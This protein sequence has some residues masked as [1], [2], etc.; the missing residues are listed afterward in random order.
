MT[1]EPD[2]AA[3]LDQH[4]AGLCAWV[5]QCAGGALT[6]AER[7]AGGSHRM[8]WQVDAAQRE[9]FLTLDA[10]GAGGEDGNARDA[11]VLSALADTPLPVPGLVGRDGPGGALLM[12]RVAGR[13]DAPSGDDLEP[14]MSDLMQHMATLH[15]LDPG[16]LSLPA[17]VQPSTAAGIALDQLEPLRKTYFATPAAHHP[18][19]DF[20]LG[21]LWRHAPRSV[22]RVA[23]VHGD[24][25]PGNMLYAEGRVRAIVDWEIAHLGDPMEDLA[26]L[27]TRDMS[28][29]IGDF[30]RRLAQ[31]QAAGGARLDVDRL[32]YYRA[33]VLIR[34]SL[35]IRLTLANSDPALVP[36]QLGAFALLLRRAASQAL[37][38]A[39]GLPLPPLPAAMP[40]APVDEHADDALWI[41][42]LAARAQ[43]ECEEQRDLMGPLFE[44][45]LQPVP[46]A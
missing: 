40:A 7:H 29:P 22:E 38:E 43:W 42:I 28:T 5:E 36:D 15:G 3:R 25:G 18:L 30:A 6:R 16:K 33:L 2:T 11:A 31:Y 27:N 9:L 20:G 10:P 41:P 46:D 37:C 32:R 26:A 39:Q 4:A 34:N 24:I 14:V 45:H 17:L 21:W 35:L 8:A 1:A 13:S 19:I 12:E 44:G 23:L